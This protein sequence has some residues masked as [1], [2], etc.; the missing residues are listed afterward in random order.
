MTSTNLQNVVAI[1]VKRSLSQFDHEDAVGATGLL[2]Q[3]GVCNLP[4][5]LT[6]KNTGETQREPTHTF[7]RQRKETTAQLDSLFCSERRLTGVISWPE[8]PRRPA[9]P[10]QSRQ[11][12]SLQSFLP[13]LLKPESESQSDDLPFQKT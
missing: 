3:A 8:L 5:L 11:Q 12:S 10:G 4:F 9:M 1:G 13:I 7:N 6:W 2:V